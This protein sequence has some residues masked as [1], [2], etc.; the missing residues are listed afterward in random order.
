[1]PIHLVS[2][3]QTMPG[4]L[5]TLVSPPFPVTILWLRLLF[6]SQGQSFP[7]VLPRL[8]CLLRAQTELLS[9]IPRFLRPPTRP[10]RSSRPSLPPPSHRRSRSLLPPQAWTSFLRS[11][12]RSEPDQQVMRRRLRLELKGK[13]SVSE[14]GTASCWRRSSL[15]RR[16][17]VRALSL[18]FSLSA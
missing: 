11:P 10:P 8:L 4:I 14:T 1:M 12:S 17:M 2:D 15:R 7:T 13:A 18:L 3:F 6:S 16:A 9:F 5:L